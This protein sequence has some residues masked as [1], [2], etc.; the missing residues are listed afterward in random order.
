MEAPKQPERK[1]HNLIFN[2]QGNL[3][4]ASHSLIDQ[5]ISDIN[6]RNPN[7][8]TDFSQSVSFRLLQNLVEVNMIQS[9]LDPAQIPYQFKIEVWQPQGESYQALLSEEIEA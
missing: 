9:G 5:A 4:L 6:E 3:F 8:K 2:P 1:W 7:D